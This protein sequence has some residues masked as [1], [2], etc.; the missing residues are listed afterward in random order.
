MNIPEVTDGEISFGTTKGLPPYDEIP[1]E[2]KPV[3]KISFPG[4]KVPKDGPERWMQLF[5]DWFF[6][7]L[8]DLNLTP[9]SGVDLEK[10]LRHIKAIM[11]S[12][13][14]DHG[15]KEAGVSYLMSQYFEHAD[16][17]KNEEVSTK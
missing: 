6:N 3:V 7:G 11:K 16:W 15:H 13:A 12:W 1:D 4:K 14:C 8:K 5:N 2:F 10:A 17:E 9:N